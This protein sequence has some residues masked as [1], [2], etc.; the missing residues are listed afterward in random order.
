MTTSS[1][2]SLLFH[3]LAITSSNFLFLTPTLGLSTKRS[4][5]ESM[6][7]TLLTSL[8]TTYS[9]ALHPDALPLPDEQPAKLL[10][11]SFR[12]LFLCQLHRDFRRRRIGMSSARCTHGGNSST[13]ARDHHSGKLWRE[14]ADYKTAHRSSQCKQIFSVP[15]IQPCPLLGFQ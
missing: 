12:D 8:K 4:L 11:P 7:M 1:L 6:T 3:T 10:S 9:R 14:N 13:S 5:S 2:D 15:D